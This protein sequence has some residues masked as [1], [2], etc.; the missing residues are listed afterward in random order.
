MTGGI[1]GTLVATKTIN[2][3]NN[4]KEKIINETF[5]RV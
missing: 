3:F 5:I 2:Y 1:S 4:R